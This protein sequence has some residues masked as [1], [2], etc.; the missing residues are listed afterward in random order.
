MYVNRWDH[1]RSPNGLRLSL[2][3]IYDEFLPGNP[4]MEIKAENADALFGDSLPFTIKAS[5]VDVPCLLYTSL[6]KPTLIPIRPRD[7][8]PLN[9]EPPGT[10][11]EGWFPRKMCIRDRIRRVCLV[12]RCQIS[13]FVLFV[14][15][16]AFPKQIRVLC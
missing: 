14:K 10:A 8:M 6:I 3:H 12:F 7:T 2:I 1:V 11:A 16:I 4:S 5:D 9:T 13:D 15:G